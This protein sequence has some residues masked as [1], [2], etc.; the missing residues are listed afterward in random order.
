MFVSGPVQRVGCIT[1]PPEPE[2]NENEPHADHPPP[3]RPR[4]HPARAAGRTAGDDADG[5][6]RRQRHHRGADP[7]QGGH[8]PRATRQPAARLTPIRLCGRGARAEQRLRKASSRRSPPARLAV[9]HPAVA[10]AGDEPTRRLALACVKVAR[11][12]QYGGS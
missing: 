4:R 9:K 3:F 7:S 5:Q 1:Y 6:C 10:R 8:G 11:D 12:E 2:D